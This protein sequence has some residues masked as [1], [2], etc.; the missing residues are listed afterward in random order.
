MLNGI[1]DNLGVSN[2]FSW[3]MITRYF[4]QHFSIK[5]ILKRHWDVLSNDKILGPVIPEKPVLIYRGAPSLRHSIAHNL[6]DPPTRPT[7]FQSLKG[8]FPCRRC[9]ICEFNA[10]RGRKCE[11]F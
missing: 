7:F 5:K 1:K 11:T 4:N 8:S 2:R 3:S 6:I 10:F 9:H